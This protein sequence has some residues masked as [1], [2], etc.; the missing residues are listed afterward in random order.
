MKCNAK[1]MLSVAAALG[2]AALLS[3]FAFPEAKLFILANTSILIALICPVS[4]LIMMW[5]MR[6][7]KDHAE[8]TP[9]DN[10]RVPADNQRPPRTAELGSDNAS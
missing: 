5:S 10:Q 4:M 7:H 9:A 6:G 8:K 1:T 3:Y 2:L